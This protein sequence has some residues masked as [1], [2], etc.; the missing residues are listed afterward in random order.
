MK[1]ITNQIA[2]FERKCRPIM[3]HIACLEE[4]GDADDG[5]EQDRGHTDDRALHLRLL[6]SPAAIASFI[7][8]SS[9]QTVWHATTG[10]RRL[11]FSNVRERMIRTRIGP[12][13]RKTTKHPDTCHQLPCSRPCQVRWDEGSPKPTSREASDAPS[14]RPASTAPWAL[15]E[16]FAPS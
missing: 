14:R 8:S 16:S 2:L 12:S 11:S 13:P 5:H 1:P 3:K 4:T 6:T 10:S 7:S 9:S 15:S